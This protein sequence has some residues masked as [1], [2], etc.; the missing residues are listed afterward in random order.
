MN[1]VRI[2]FNTKT[3][4]SRGTKPRTHRLPQC[5]ATGLARFRDRHQ[6][7][8]AAKAATRSQGREASMFALPR[9]PWLARRDASGHLA[10]P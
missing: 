10:R 4:T 8:D 1:A 3:R 6:A 2:N 7:R 9:V 5:P